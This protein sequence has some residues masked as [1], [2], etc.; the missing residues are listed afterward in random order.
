MGK[1]CNMHRVPRNAVLWWKNLKEKGYSLQIGY[2][3]YRVPL[4]VAQG[5]QARTD[6]GTAYTVTEIKNPTA[7]CLHLTNQHNGYKK[8]V[9]SPQTWRPMTTLN[10]N[11]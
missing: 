4:P 5:C 7:E 1:T 3:G 11:V 2:E 10:A 9:T 8:K 6:R